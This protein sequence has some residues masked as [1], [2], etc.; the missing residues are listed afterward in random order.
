MIC[1]LHAS[2]DWE[3]LYVIA[4][5]PDQHKPELLRYFYLCRAAPGHAEKL[6]IGM[7]T[8][9]NWDFLARAFV[10]RSPRFVGPVYF[11]LDDLKPVRL[12]RL[13]APAPGRGRWRWRFGRWERPNKKGRVTA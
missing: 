3:R 2:P 7:G 1:Y 4:E 8:V 13:P 11:L 12:E 9:V 5:R 10:L 6:G